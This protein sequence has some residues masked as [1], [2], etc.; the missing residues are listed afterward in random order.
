MKQ[1][2]KDLTEQFRQA[3]LEI[4]GVFTQA[5]EEDGDNA[6]FH[7]VDATVES[8]LKYV[9]LNRLFRRRGADG[10]ILTF[11]RSDRRKGSILL[12]DSA[13]QIQKDFYRIVSNDF[14]ENTE[15]E[16]AEFCVMLID[17][18][19]ELL[20]EKKHFSDLSDEVKTA[21]LELSNAVQVMPQGVDEI[22]RQLT[23][24]IDEFN[25]I[26]VNCVDALGKF[27]TVNREVV[28]KQVSE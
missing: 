22:V 6:V 28:S 11:G 21:Y 18:C 7:A 12:D 8:M 4:R 2:K 15:E 3:V 9:G 24:N 25:A 20:D 13:T 5:D 14:A 1:H 23:E 16:F 17:G 27:D 10:I 19:V 26:L